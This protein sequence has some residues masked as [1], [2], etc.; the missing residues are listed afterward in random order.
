MKSHPETAEILFETPLDVNGIMKL[1]PHRYPFL[2]IDRIIEA[3]RGYCVAEKC[4]TINEPYFQGHFPGNPVMPGVLQ[5]EAIAQVAGV[6]RIAEPESAGKIG[7]FV[8]IDGVRFRRQVVPGDVL[9]IVIQEIGR[10]KSFGK[11][12]GKIFVGE[13]LACE[14]TLSFMLVDKPQ[15]M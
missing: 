9:R 1:L 14:A 12:T 11:C 10:K 15:G 3:R 13:D 7:L 4:V 2:F 5:V 6:V 8:G